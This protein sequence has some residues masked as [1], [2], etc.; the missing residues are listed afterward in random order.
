MFSLF[1]KEGA[2]GTDIPFGRQKDEGV[3]WPVM[4]VEIKNGLHAV[5]DVIIFFGQG[6]SS[7]GE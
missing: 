3:A 5:I 6:S 7:A 4:L 1:A 2:A